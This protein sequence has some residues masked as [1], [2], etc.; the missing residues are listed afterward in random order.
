MLSVRSATR[1][2]A[3]HCLLMVMTSGTA[4]AA[5]NGCL[6]CHEGIER[7]SDGGMQETIETM[8]AD[9]GDPGGCVV[10]HGGDPATAATRPRPP[11][12]PPTRARPRT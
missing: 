8:G 5:Q 3:A 10:C 2:I 11:P 6:S 7:F 9:L 4:E 1:V 12:R